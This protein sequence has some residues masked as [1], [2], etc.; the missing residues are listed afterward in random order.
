MPSLM[1]KLHAED[2]TAKPAETAAAKAGEI[3]FDGKRR[4]DNFLPVGGQA[5]LV[6][7]AISTQSTTQHGYSF[8]DSPANRKDA[9]DQNQQGRNRKKDE[10]WQAEFD[11][12]LEP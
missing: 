8:D 7:E 1:D 3:S 11:E 4:V 6:R 10:A 12:Q 9:Q 2:W 5:E